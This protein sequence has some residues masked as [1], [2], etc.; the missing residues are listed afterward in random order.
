MVSHGFPMVFPWFSHGFPMNSTATPFSL[1]VRC[2]TN[3]GPPGEIPG[4]RCWRYRSRPSSRV[5]KMRCGKAGSRDRNRWGIVFIFGG[6]ANAS[7]QYFPRKPSHLGSSSLMCN[8]YPIKGA[9]Q[10]IQ[11]EVFKSKLMRIALWVTANL[12]KD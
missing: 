11:M 7:N 10:M 3:A 8:S 12:T 9:H 6:P 4:C 1:Q 2:A 5:S